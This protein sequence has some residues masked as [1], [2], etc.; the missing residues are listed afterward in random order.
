V[1]PSPAAA[2]SARH[3]VDPEAAR[4]VRVLF[5]GLG[6]EIYELELPYIKLPSLGAPI[7]P[8][9]WTR[10]RSPQ[11]AI[12]PNGPPT[13]LTKDLADR[14]R[15][16]RRAGANHPGAG[17]A[18]APSDQC[19]QNEQRRCIACTQHPERYRRGR[20]HRASSS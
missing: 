2:A 3:P 7:M 12:D 8:A 5:I 18:K 11:P 16:T 9:D 10:T 15:R 17:P 14:I 20:D 19:E 6:E 4:G 1:A 13:R